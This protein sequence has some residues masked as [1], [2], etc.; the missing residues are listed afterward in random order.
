MNLKLKFVFC[1][2]EWHFELHKNS[3]FIKEVFFYIKLYPTMVVIKIGCFAL[4]CKKIDSFSLYIPKPKNCLFFRFIRV[5]W[6]DNS[7][8]SSKYLS[9][10]Y[11]SGVWVCSFFC[12]TH[13]RTLFIEKDFLFY[14]RTHTHTLKEFPHRIQSKFDGNYKK[15]KNVQLFIYRYNRIFFSDGT[16]GLGVG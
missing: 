10:V 6:S 7:D 1:L 3:I 15:K 8:K 16:E 2:F 5:N 14:I 13:T 12:I 4:K 11:I 9:F